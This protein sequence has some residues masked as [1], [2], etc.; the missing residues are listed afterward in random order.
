MSNPALGMLAWPRSAITFHDY[1][2]G[3]AKSPETWGTRFSF[4]SQKFVHVPMHEESMTNNLW[5]WDEHK[6]RMRM[7][8]KNFAG[9]TS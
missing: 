7:Y 3:T 4:N 5:A 9:H 8:N 6:T 1:V 2:I